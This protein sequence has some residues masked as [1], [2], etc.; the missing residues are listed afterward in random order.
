MAGTKITKIT[1]N[2]DRRK[3]EEY[4]KN[5]NKD[6]GEILNTKQNKTKKLEHN[7]NSIE[8]M[9]EK[10][11]FPLSMVFGFFGLVWFGYIEIVSVY[12]SF[13][14]FCFRISSYGSIA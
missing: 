6:D 1:I 8:L 11:L 13:V 12:F 7:K 10:N 4:K 3:K 9:V 2:P 14:V 5:C